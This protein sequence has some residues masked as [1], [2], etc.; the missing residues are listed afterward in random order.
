MC[1]WLCTFVALWIVLWATHGLPSRTSVY[2]GCPCRDPPMNLDAQGCIKAK[3]Q[4][5]VVVVVW[6]CQCLVVVFQTSS[7]RGFTALL[8]Y[9]FRVPC[10]TTILDSRSLE[11]ENTCSFSDLLSLLTASDTSLLP[12]MPRH[13][14]FEHLFIICT[15]CLRSESLYL[16]TSRISF[17][18][19]RPERPQSAVRRMQLKI[20][21]GLCSRPRQSTIG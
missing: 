19:S 13:K 5:S 15:G 4:P 8:L 18:T 20:P 9:A 11:C 21:R 3:R 12:S 7:Q 17:S 1:F 10:L 6:S 2:R 14:N 16:I